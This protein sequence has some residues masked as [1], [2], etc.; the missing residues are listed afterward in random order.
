MQLNKILLHKTK[1]IALQRCDGDYHLKKLK[2]TFIKILH[3]T[4]VYKII[5]LVVILITGTHLHA[6]KNTVV[7]QK[8]TLVLP[9]KDTVIVKKDSMVV[10]KKRNIFHTI[11]RI[12]SKKHPDTASIPIA[13]ALVIKAE[14]PYLPYQGKIIRHIETKQFGFD[15]SF[16]DTSKQSKYYG[17]RFLNKL[18]HNTRSWQIRNNLFIHENTPLNT[19][20]LSE[21]ERYLRSLNYIQDARILVKEVPG[22][23]DSVDLQV[24]T[25]DLFSITGS[26]SSLSPNKM[27]VKASEQNILG[28]GQRVEVV[29]L[30]EKLRNPAFGYS[31]LYNINNINHSFVNATLIYSNIDKNIKDNRRNEKA[32]LLQLD[33]P[34]T[35][36]YGRVAGGFTIGSNQS[37]NDYLEPDSFFYHYK[38]NVIDGWVGYNIGV[39]RFLSDNKMHDR[40][41][42][43][44]RYFKNN[45][46]ELPFQ[47]GDQYNQ[48]YNDTKGVL[49]QFTFFR[50]DFYKTNYIYGFGT[51][52]DIP[53]GYNV[54]V[55][56][57][58]YKQLNL[59]RPYAG[60]DASF[61]RFTNQGHFIQYFL[62]TGGFVNKKHIEDAG[63]LL[64]SSCFSRLYIFRNF[65]LRQ[66]IRI[67]FTRQFNRVTLD[68]LKINNPFGIRYFG[69]DSAFGSRRISVHGETLTYLKYKAFGFQF[70]PFV[71]HDLSVLT[72]YGK[73]LGKSACYW[74]LGGGVRTRNEN[75]IFGTMELRFVYFP[76]QIQGLN[77]FLIKSTI[78]LRFRY[79]SSY[80]RA[81]DLIQLNTDYSNSIF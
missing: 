66:Y 23:T 37:N 21:N 24:V 33:R 25:K 41:F 30:Y 65:K 14:V 39:K 56:G 47:I 42:V 26:L 34:L 13:P 10:K 16:T 36:A 40:K 67:S 9:K 8:D 57:G 4:S 51:T 55:T 53:T 74:S 52:E 48:R 78:N 60:V 5:L 76:R 28:T 7:V 22:S 17:T 49:G 81:P 79:N 38:Y 71:F 27:R 12:I 59:A 31:A 18:H 54:A 20:V 68:P 64:G 62:R 11:E 80:V 43:S 63:F 2:N 1:T 46:T 19:Y 15:K 35:S 32:I 70:S 6:Q 29:S 75:L 77:P 3:H 58:W 72:P 50:Q 44:L 61:Y 45:F 69:S 73:T